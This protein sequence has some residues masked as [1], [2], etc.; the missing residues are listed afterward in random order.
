MHAA[1]DTPRR[2]P[3]RPAALA[4]A[5]CAALFA[6][7]PAAAQTNEFVREANRLSA[8]TSGAVDA[9]EVLFPA[10]AA[11]DT[12][13]APARELGRN[14][15]M[16]TPD[17]ARWAALERWAT[18]DEQQEVLDAL[19]TITEDLEDRYILGLPYTRDGLDQSWIDAGLYA[20]APGGVLAS[21]DLS[22]LGELE[23]RLVALATFEAARRSLEGD[24]SGSLEVAADLIRFGRIMTERAMAREMIWGLE[25]MFF[26]S[27]AMLDAVYR[28]RDAFDADAL[29]RTADEIDERALLMSQIPP[30]RGDA[31]VARQVFTFTTPE[32][33][34]PQPDKLAEVFSAAASADRPLLAFG[35]AAAWRDR[36][37]GHADWFDIGD[38]IDNVQGDYESRWALPDLN[39]RLFERPTDFEKMDKRRYA[40]IA[41]TMGRFEEA[42]P[43]RRE[44]QIQ[45]D[46]AYA[47]LGALAF[48]AKEGRFAPS[49]RA[50]A[51]TYVPRL[52]RDLNNRNE[53]AKNYEHFEYFVPV[54]D[55]NFGRRELPRPH[56]VTVYMDPNTG[57]GR[58]RGFSSDGARI[59]GRN[60]PAIQTK[61]RWH[62]DDPGSLS[63]LDGPAVIYFWATW[64]GPCK[65]AM[66]TM[67][68]AVQSFGPQ[69]VTFIGVC[70]TREGNNMN[71]TLR[72]HN[73]AFPSAVDDDDK[74]ADAYGVE[75]WPYVVVL[76]SDR[77][78]RAAGVRPNRVAEVVALV[79]EDETGAGLTGMDDIGGMGGMGD[80]GDMGGMD[81]MGMAD[82]SPEVADAFGEPPAGM[83]NPDTGEVD[84]GLLRDWLVDGIRS[85]PMSEDE[86][87]ETN[88]MLAALAD[89]GVDA[90][91]VRE[92][93]NEASND[94]EGLG[95]LLMLFGGAL[96]PLIDPLLA[97]AEDALAEPALR[98]AI[99]AAAAGGASEQQVRDAL[100]DAARAAIRQSRLDEFTRAGREV[101]QAM[102]PEMMGGIFGGMGLDMGTGPAGGAAVITASLGE[103]TFILYSV[104]PDGRDDE[105]EA[106]GPGGNDNLI[107]PPLPT[108][109]RE[110]G[111]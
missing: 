83:Y 64:C 49:I 106:V 33:G 108:L 58:L 22:Y 50:V 74:T 37:A 36:A 105:A 87:A 19:A 38:M 96:D 73:M 21:L 98:D 88:E 57:P 34:R 72:D 54:R 99:D 40:L 61:G 31:V 93:F 104:G 41:E 63:E 80:M 82:V 67:N 45:L 17:D 59:V 103:D 90:D 9:V 69:G 16:L 26:G 12:P 81:G 35:A 78:V 47:A 4:A 86:L 11:M 28:N 27:E 97:M 51:P 79:L 77:T 76:D 101:E 6:A 91:N 92:K 66:P 5:A 30:A 18:R 48:A 84:A 29:S 42:I 7:A 23:S 20:H 44:L 15:I 71:R 95:G 1:I 110:F 32:R 53:L 68:E 102:G 13:P 62:M 60:A 10:L 111:S 43:F 3:T 56:D 25:L 100:A 14:V 65:A 109:R 85:A 70:N 94:P 24:G 89:M 75:F 107:Y 46:G 52:P 39:D 8:A 55:Q 2:R